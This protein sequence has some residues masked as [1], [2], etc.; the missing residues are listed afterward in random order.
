MVLTGNMVP[1]L[2][3]WLLSLKKSLK[4]A[5]RDNHVR[6]LLHLI[7]P[8]IFSFHVVDESTVGNFVATGSRVVACKVPYTSMVGACLMQSFNILEYYFCF[9]LD[10]VRAQ[11][12]SY[13]SRYLF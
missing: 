8:Y 1:E 10:I 2:Q 3:K 13:F 7:S 9:G 5:C 12:F 11:Q 6:L 4:G